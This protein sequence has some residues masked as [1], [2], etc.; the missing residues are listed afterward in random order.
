[1]ISAFL[2]SILLFF[3]PAVHHSFN[4][5]D[6]VYYSDSGYAEFTSTV[7]LHT[8]T[9]ESDHLT[10]MI[11][12]NENLIDFYIDLNTLKT[13]IERRDRD[14]YQTL[15]VKDHPFAEFTGSLDSTYSVI[16]DFHQ[17][18]S[19]TAIGE[20]TINGVI[21]NLEVEGFLHNQ[22][23]NLILVA[24]WTLSISDYDIVPPGILF[25]R[26]N[27]IQDIKIEV[28]LKPIPKSSLE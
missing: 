3:Q 14:M 6:T 5:A 7:P 13:G 28:T 9:G 16:S 10:G 18:Q 8:F 12:L 23:G 1:M 17:K 22:D 21:Q 15:N 20:F 4:I 25:Y 24:E 2:L 19:V 26:V 11:D 27:E